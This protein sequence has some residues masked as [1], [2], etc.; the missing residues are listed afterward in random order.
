MN[1]LVSGGGGRGEKLASSSANHFFSTIQ[2][3]VTPFVFNIDFFDHCGWP[4]LDVRGF[5][6][7]CA[8]H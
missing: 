1:A 8:D 7:Y 3:S 6:E 5:Y 2:F 4:S